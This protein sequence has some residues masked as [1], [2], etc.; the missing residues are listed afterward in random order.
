MKRG[1]EK[2]TKNFNV[3]RSNPQSAIPKRFPI[4]LVSFTFEYG[5]E[6]VTPPSFSTHPGP[7]AF[8]PHSIFDNIIFYG[9]PK[10][11]FVQLV[12]RWQ[13]F[14]PNCFGND[15]AAWGVTSTIF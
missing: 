5:P 4:S 11:Q 8:P 14:S 6:G 9:R 12:A 3:Q 7:S 10:N 1:E 13:N 15:I 2:S